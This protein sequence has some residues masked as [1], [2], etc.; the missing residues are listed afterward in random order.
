MGI[1]RAC[2]SRDIEDYEPY[3]ICEL[4]TNEIKLDQVQGQFTSSTVCKECFYKNLDNVYLQLV[5][6]GRELL[7]P[8]N[9]LQIPHN[10]YGKFAGG[11]IEVVDWVIGIK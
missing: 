8:L 5:V 9:Q 11:D 6:D 4:C 7:I 3:D 10:E 1:C 2:G